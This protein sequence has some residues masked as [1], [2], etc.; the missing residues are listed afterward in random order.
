[1]GFRGYY[2]A[3]WSPVRSEAGEALREASN[4]LMQ[5]SAADIEKLWQIQVHKD[6]QR[7]GGFELLQEHDE[8]V[9]ECPLESVP[10]LAHR[11]EE[12]AADIGAGCLTV[13]LSVVVECGPSW[14]ETQSV[15]QATLGMRGKE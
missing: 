13:P 12:A 6:I 11:L 15:W 1:M 7:S 9:L 10:Y 3:Y 4:F 5:A 8:L 14:G 2:P